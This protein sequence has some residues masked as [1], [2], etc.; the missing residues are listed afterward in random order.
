MKQVGFAAA[1]RFVLID[2]KGVHAIHEAEQELLHK[3]G[4]GGKCYPATSREIAKGRQLEKVAHRRPKF[5]RGFCSCKDGCSSSDCK[6]CT[7]GIG[8]WWESWVN[9]DGSKE[10]WGCE[11]GGECKSAV[12]GHVYDEAEGTKER[13]AVLRK[14]NDA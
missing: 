2:E 3:D 4:L 14:V 7:E 10:G 11:C 8:C 9:E 12:R 1:A 6:C 5:D 13:Q